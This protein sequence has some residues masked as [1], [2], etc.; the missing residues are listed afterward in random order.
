MLHTRE[1]LCCY[2][3]ASCEKLLNLFLLFAVSLAT[4][5]KTLKSLPHY[6]RTTCFDRQWSSSG[7]ISTTILEAVYNIGINALRPYRHNIFSFMQCNV[8]CGSCMVCKH[9]SMW[10]WVSDI[11]HMTK[12]MTNLQ[13]MWPQRHEGMKNGRMQTGRGKSKFLQKN[14][15]HWS[16]SVYHGTEL[17]PLPWETGDYS[18]GKQVPTIT[19]HS[20]LIHCDILNPSLHL[21]W[22]TTDIYLLHITT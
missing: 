3:I 2:S 12:C 16:H 13:Q 21:I 22:F 6:W 19:I 7:A 17:R 15:S 5:I 4:C 10:R 20:L 1:R 9:W 11:S 8:Q 18:K 14:L